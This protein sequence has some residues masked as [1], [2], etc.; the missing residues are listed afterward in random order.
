MGYSE[1]FIKKH[2]GKRW[3]RKQ[4]EKGID[5]T[6]LELAYTERVLIPLQAEWKKLSRQERRE[7]LWVE[8][9]INYFGGGKIELRDKGKCGN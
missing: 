7:W 4:R 6:T 8:R 2:N 5:T 1:L 9:I 3:L